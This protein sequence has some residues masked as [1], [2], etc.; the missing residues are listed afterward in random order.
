MYSKT[1]RTKQ[2]SPS[3][4]RQQNNAAGNDLEFYSTNKPSTPY[5]DRVIPTLRHN[6]NNNTTNNTNTN[7]KIRTDRPDTNIV[8][9]DQQAEQNNMINEAVVPDQS[10][11]LEQEMYDPIDG[12]EEMTESEVRE[13]A[14][15]ND[16]LGKQIV[17]KLY[18]KNFQNRE[19][20]IQ[21]VFNNLTNY[22]G[23]KEEAKGLMRAAAILVAK[24][25]KD[26]VFSI[27]NN[28]LKLEQFLLND[29]AKRFSLGK[30][31]INYVLEKCFPV[32]L[33][34]TGDTN[35]RLRQRAHEYIVEMA[36]FPEIKPLNTIPLYCITPFKLHIA[37]RL[38]L[39]R[40]EILEDLMKQLGYK[41]NG[42]TVDN[43][44]K[45]CSQA[46]E[47]TSGEVRELAAKIL[48]QMYKENGQ[49]V[50]RYL[51]PDNEMN[52]RNKKY[53]ILYD[54]FDGIDGKPIQTYDKVKFIFFF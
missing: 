53:R 45:F 29:F 23:E 32:L 52:R 17:T 48:I 10:E 30:Q 26:N 8:E 19:D 28:A 18:S 2:T 41:D 40:V 51:P 15:M 14:L 22:K 27:F 49:T 35:A 24:M 11:N 6:S 39:S 50:R 33:H 34:R 21:E 1:S 38:A 44:S 12:T 9:E 16:Y 36:I 54:A 20:A 25:S 47:H 4:N 13:A 37:P 46:L 42:L 7:N 43:I 5:D 31:E 3:S